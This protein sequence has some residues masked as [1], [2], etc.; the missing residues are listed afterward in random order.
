[1]QISRGRAPDRHWG[2]V[3]LA[4]PASGNPAYFVVRGWSWEG[5]FETS[6][7]TEGVCPD[8]EKL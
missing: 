8:Q 2:W 4:R 5:Q 1:M 3:C 6:E 7:G